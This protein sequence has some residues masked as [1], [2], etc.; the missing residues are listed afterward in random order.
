MIQGCVFGG[1]GM[2]VGEGKKTIMVVLQEPAFAR[3]YHSGA[4]DTIA[5]LSLKWKITL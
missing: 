3:S 5:P 1:R 2:C 4:S